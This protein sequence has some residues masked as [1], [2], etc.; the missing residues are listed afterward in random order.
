M[1]KIYPYI[2]LVILFFFSN[3]SFAQQDSMAIKFANGN[4]ITKNNTNNVIF[5]TKQIQSSFYQNNYYVA[6][7]FSKLPS[8][9][10][11]RLLQK[12][13]ITIY[14]YLPPNAY[15]AIIQDN[16]DFS[17]SKYF[18]IISIN[19]VP[20]FYKTDKR[21]LS[22]QSEIANKEEQK[23]IAV[24]HFPNINQQEVEK[25][26]I[27]NG[28][29]I[30][31]TKF[32]SPT[33]IFI[34]PEKKIINKI[35][36]LPFVTTITLVSLQDK[37]LNY[38]NSG[39]A[40]ISGVQ[41]LAGKNLTGKDVTI[42]VGDNSD[43]SNTH[44]DFAG[45]VINRVYFFPNNHGTHTSGTAAGAGILNPKFKGVAPK[46]TI[47]SQILSDVIV[48]TP[49]Y[50][51][52]YNMIA[53]NNS[54]TSADNGCNGNS[55][56]DFFSNYIDNQ[57]L[58]YDEVLHCFAAGNDGL[59]SCS[60]Y[61]T[62]F[63]TIKSGW[64]AA[65]NVLTVGNIDASKYLISNSS[66]RGPVADGRIKPE[67]VANG[68]NTFSAF[69]NNTYNT[70][71]GTSMAAPVVTGAVALLQQR[72]KQLHGSYAKSALIKNLLCNSAQDQGTPGPDYTY[73]FGMINVRKAMEMMEK[74]QY[75]KGTISNG[76]TQINNIS[77]PPGARRLKVMLYWNDKAAADNAANALINDL[78]LTVT[79]PSNNTVFPLVLNANPAHVSDPAIPGVDHI[80]NIE[81]VIIDNPEV[82]NY[83][84]NVIGFNIPNANQIYFITY[85][86]DMNGV[87]LEYP[88]G[89]ETW[90]PNEN[91]II[92]F[93]GYG[94]ETD[95]FTLEFSDNNGINW[96]LI[97]DNIPGNSQL[98]NW[99]VPNTITNNALIRIKRNN[100]NYS[101]VS[102]FPFTILGQPN[103]TITNLC[104][105]YVEL[106]WLPIAGA[107][108]YEVMQLKG[109]SMS[110][111]ATTPLT[112][113]IIAGLESNTRYW[114]G[115][116]A[117]NG[118]T[119]GRRSLSV[120]TIPNNGACNLNLF[121]NDLK[122]VA[123]TEPV[124]GREFTSSAPK[125]T[126]PI[127]VTIKNLDNIAS[128]SAFDISYQ[129][130]GGAV[131]TQNISPN[132]PA[133]GTFT[134]TFPQHP[135]GGNNYDIKVWIDKP[136]DLQK[137]ND[138][139]R[140]LVR[141]LTNPAVTLPS[142]NG[143]ETTAINDFTA[144]TIGLSG[145][146]RLDFFASTSKGRARAF[147]NT[148]FA[149][150]GTKALTL[151][152]TP[153]A[154]TPQADS[155][156]QTVNL[157]NYNLNNH[158]LRLDFYY[159]D[160]GQEQ[161][162]GNKVWIRGSDNN[163]WLEAYDLDNDA[164]STGVY[165]KVSIN[166][167]NILSNAL[168]LQNVGSSF[169]IKLGQEGT[170]S[171]N[172]VNPIT[173][174]D[175]GYTFDDI[176]ISEAFN[177]IAAEKII[178]PGINTCALGNNVPIT[179]TV[180]NYSNITQNNIPVSYKI[181]GGSTITESI[182]SI[183]AGGSVD[184]TF[185]MHY[186]FSAF[187]NY[188]IDCWVS[189]VSDTYKSNDTIRYSLHNTPFVNTYPYLESFETTNGG[190]YTKGNNSSWQWGIPNA[191]IINKAANG[192]KAW[193][194]N[195]T[196]SYNNDELSY[197]YSPCFD[198]SSL[199]N[200]VLSFSHI[201]DLELDFDF[202]WIEYSTDG[203]ASW[204]RLGPGAGN[205]NWYDDEVN[206]RWKQSNTK[207][208]VASID[209]P[210]NGSNVRFRIALFS[211][212]GVAK[213]GVGIDDIHIFDKAGIYSGVDVISQT[214]SVNGNN[215]TH[216]VNDG[217]RIA[218]IN[219]NNNNLGSTSAEVYFNQG[220]VRFSNNQQYYLD[221]NI[222][223]KSTNS[224]VNPVNIR[225]Y[226]THAEALALM[227]A[228]GCNNCTTISDPYVS[229]VTQYS[230]STDDENGN[231]E[232][233]STGVRK[234]IL[235]ADVN[236]VPFE[237]GY[238]AEFS[239][240][241]FSEFWIN[242]GGINANQPIPTSLLYFEAN[243][244]L[245]SVQL[246]WSTQN[247]NNTDEF[248]IERSKD[249]INF[250]AIGKVPAKQVSGVQSYEFF[251]NSP[252]SGLNYYRLKSMKNNNPVVYSPIRKVIFSR[253]NEDITLYPNPV[254]KGILNIAAS[255]NCR[256]A[257]LL[258]ATGKQIRAYTLQGMYPSIDVSPIAGGVYFLK[259]YTD[260]NTYTKKIVIQ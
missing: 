25:K 155:L 33:T 45:R 149:R 27:A 205:T 248:V 217:K 179:V 47:V 146:D 196:G 62:S 125:A 8:E 52:D 197:L 213:E 208:H 46:S 64:Q 17:R 32:N 123:I 168:P 21:L 140:K 244:K 200:P 10:E 95:P 86:M 147:V 260:N 117:K 23:I 249:G 12:S 102:D 66:S 194:T 13:G 238:Y 3:D 220:P 43:I 166:I 108:E 195:L 202:N 97:A 132:I 79:N 5:D 48:N 240:N 115:V 19:T 250:T 143:F 107:T 224:P 103:V 226:F 42:G 153:A 90:V 96:T 118:T 94:N 243:K 183:P 201:L 233:D 136:G 116:R 229:G 72:H 175:D 7:Q 188:D 109:D 241:N 227:N 56:Y 259:I 223:I 59:L 28:A 73:G 127:K 124:N 30:V 83:K 126:S 163:N 187:I 24:N 6:L 167:N 85:Q 178:S 154:L 106:K 67:I 198:L 151:D 245:Y 145:D 71:S 11:L 35:A 186:D 53:T 160:Q 137:A 60:N 22:E 26:L 29:V 206:K 173:K 91:E 169:Q 141:L 40:A 204:Q 252:F 69:V 129:I 180:K 228:A 199:S 212:V 133:G 120:T 114:F 192:Q 232:D 144:P 15:W 121:D 77:V 242:N 184:Y 105:G 247:E 221:R 98:Y 158:Q 172:N 152:Q 222:V 41:S 181:N 16:F 258:D 119:A 138:T 93:N 2:I 82:G 128:N 1:T 170:T 254:T 84:L 165:K 251:D 135:L 185:S 68:F 239:V 54:Y 51:T 80:N 191:T 161:Y 34:Q 9:E 236:I 122:V 253:P 162:D 190:W 219:A 70:T 209:I 174:N 237:N 100:T 92:R 130:N 210:T 164:F 75:F 159:R 211:D 207:W 63:A 203:G 58:V 81:Q 44:I 255:G 257:I 18:H 76:Q 111:I 50:V 49:A 78:D 110:V 177:D 256:Q 88:F 246:L 182:P 193:V 139:T 230:G 148:G 87:I 189:L 101:D 150:T 225:F 31:K 156:I 113:F 39:S 214:V 4:L 131:F 65:K 235:P 176:T 38:N 14:N 234:F 89:G 134:Y 36:D 157:S 57:S 215:W 55:Q 99:I 231:I 218:S 112:N 142:F 37:I 171:A 61:P 104:E 74:N 216:F 20:G